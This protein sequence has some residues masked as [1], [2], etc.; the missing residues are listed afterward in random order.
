MF[1]EGWDKRYCLNHL[2]AEAKKP[3]G[4]TYSTVHFFGDKTHV[5]GN[6]YELYSDPRTIGHA[7]KNP[8]DTYRQIKELF[9]L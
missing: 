5:G 9:N 4:I 1:P 7:V 8:E 2:E 3:G 6:D